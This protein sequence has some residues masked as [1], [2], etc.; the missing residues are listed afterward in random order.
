MSE[1]RISVIIPAFNHAAYLAQGIDSVLAQTLPPAEVVVVDDGSTDATPAVLAPYAGRI[2]VLRQANAG[3]S[4]ARNRGAAEARGDWLAFMDADDAWEP[5]RL[6]TMAAFRRDHPDVRVVA[7][8]ARV[9]DAAGSPTGSILPRG[10]PPDRIT[11]LDLLTE[12]K[13][14]INSAGVLV[15]RGEF[16]ET[17]GFD[18][19][20]AAVADCDM[21]L[22]LSRRGPIGF[23]ARPLLLYRVHAANMS[24]DRL[25][26]AREWLRMLAKFAQAE[27]EF[28]RRHAAVLRRARAGQELRLGRELLVRG[29][30][31]SGGR[32]EARQALVRSLRAAPRPR[33]LVYLAVACTVPRLY[34]RFRRWELGRRYR[35]NVAAG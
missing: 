6:E 11:T 17:G 34:G 28:V 3:V 25:S 18:R 26:N 23:V 14:S 30:G 10:A 27:P 29:G 4:A 20:L 13:G 24:G 22:R 21:W 15:D 31:D 9:M 7:T 5:D 2:R 8:A 35:R 32:R 16:L 1:P 12:D 33:A 19:D